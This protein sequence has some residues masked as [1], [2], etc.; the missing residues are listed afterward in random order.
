[1]EGMKAQICE[2]VNLIANED[3]LNFVYDAA[4]VGLRWGL[5]TDKDS[6]QALDSFVT[7]E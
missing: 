3:A 7:D 6:E 5:K 4:I 2:L 1:M